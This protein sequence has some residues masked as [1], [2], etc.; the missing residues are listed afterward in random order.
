MTRTGNSR[1]ITRLG[2]NIALDGVLAAFGVVLAYW[3]ETPAMLWPDPPALPLA[4]AAAIW[5]IGVPFG[6][7][8]LHWRFTSLQDLARIGGA[9]LLA[10]VMLTLLLVG[11]GL[12]LPGPGFPIL[13]ALTLLVTLTVPRLLYRLARQPAQ[14]PDTVNAATAI[15]VGTGETAE[16]FLAALARVAAAPY[17]VTGL[18]ALSAKHTGRRLHGFDIAGAVDQAESVLHRLQ[19]ADKIP[20]LL[21]ITSPELS[22]DAG[23]EPDRTRPGGADG[24]SVAADRDRGSAEPPA[25]CAR[26]RRHGGVDFRQ[27]GACHRCRRQHRR[28]ASAPGRGVRTGGADAAG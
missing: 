18:M 26:P 22:G 3:L 27:T 5:L 12:R 25:S 14:K 1:F 13:L 8:R 15:L 20:D 19:S 28:R 7:S 9:A 10:G 6:L 2:V 23:A 24:N 4:G 17:R 11:A 16:L 21:I